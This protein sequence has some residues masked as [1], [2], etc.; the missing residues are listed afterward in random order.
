MHN[1]MQMMKF[2]RLNARNGIRTMEYTR[3]IRTVE[4]ARRNLHGGIHTKG[5]ILHDGIC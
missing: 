5:W 1:G 4:S 2:T 3:Q